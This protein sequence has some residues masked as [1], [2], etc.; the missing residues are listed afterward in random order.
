M[1]KLMFFYY[2]IALGIVVFTTNLLP[3]LLKNITDGLVF[4]EHIIKNNL[5]T[6]YFGF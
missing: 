5:K 4:N 2:V 3:Q 1:N 6:K